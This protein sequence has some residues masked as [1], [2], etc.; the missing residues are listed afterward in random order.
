MYQYIWD[1]ETGGLLLTTELSKFSKEP[2]PVYSSELT[3]LGFDRYWNYPKDDSAPLMW[4]EANNY[5]YCGR[6]VAKTQGGSLYT[7]PEIQILD[8][9]EPE[10]APLRF[11]DIDGM[12]EK[13]RKLME[14]LEQ[15][16]I[17]KVYNTYVKFKER[18]DVF[19]VAFSGGKDSVVTLDIVQRA[20]PH[21]EFLVLFGDTQMEFSDTYD[22]VGKIEQWCKETNISFYR[23]K[24]EFKPEYTW[25]IIGPP[26]QKMRWCCS[27]HKT[28]PQILT[29]RK[30]TGNPHFRGMA[31]MG[32]RGDES[33]TR[34]RYE[35][36][37]YGTKHQGQFDYYPIFEWG[38]AELF[39]YIYEKKLTLNETYKKGN[40]RAG[41][42]V[43]PMEASKNSWFKRQSY[44]G[45]ECNCHS[46]S[47]FNKIIVQQTFAKELSPEHLKEFMDIGVWKSRHNGKK[48]A[49]PRDIYHEEK[50]GNEI[51]ITLDAMSADW[52]EWLKTVGEPNYLPDGKSVE[53]YCDNDCYLMMYDNQNGKYIFKLSTGNNTQK[54]IYFVSWIK[55]ILKKSA[56]CI[57]CRVCEANCPNG[58]IHMAD[59]KIHI[60]DHCVKCKK[61][62]KINNGCVVAASQMLPKEDKMS[63]SIDQ[64]KN[65]GVQ[66][67]WVTSY[68]EKGDDFW[69]DSR[70]GSE[71]EK[72]LKKFLRHA[73]VTDKKNT[74]S[75]FG[76][77]ITDIGA[78]SPTS[79]ALMLCN[80]VYTAQFNW[81][82]MN[83][84]FNR[85][86]SQVELDEMLKDNLT[87]N[88][89]KNVISGFKNTFYT[90]PIISEEIGFGIV[91]T[92]E[93][94][95]NIYLEEAKRLPWQSPDP[96]V[97]L[98]SLY[99]F[100]EKCGG[101]YQFSLS[102][103]LD[104]S[105]ERDGVSPTR[106]FGLDYDTMLPILN[107]LSVNY[108]DFISASFSLGLDTINLREDKSSQDVLTIF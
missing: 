48:L 40:S 91:R 49:F 75:S 57:M 14:T 69:N 50:R 74:L 5:I 55:T 46:T 17:Q 41:C 56:Y 82:V 60:D 89:R 71:M 22:V 54:E 103:L 94:G 15:E 105:I 4:A 42:L 8:T 23:A 79:W 62:Y 43:C 1:E 34:S 61:C 66:F 7:A 52:K 102:T 84:D 97:I 38:S 19:Y 93:K 92:I 65:M 68:F 100:A 85:L 45:D 20:L 3:I 16:T 31:M 95:G 78:K 28:A 59:G 9:P 29:L 25:N 99:K 77:I 73:E 70:L 67:Q 53:I 51:I 32:V 44:A 87:A 101:L 96:R 2:R 108:P 12:V 39:M 10:D 58:Y 13:N 104:D 30:I 36:I 11:V 27:V 80:L 33:V 83:I 106:I 76:K 35:E 72:S 63:G 6:L 98:Y 90:N 64:Y 88:S 81:W 24:S 107:G 26:A 86:Y 37:N 47:F 21:D 18:V